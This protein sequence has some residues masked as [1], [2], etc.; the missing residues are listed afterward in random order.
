MN[1]RVTLLKDYIISFA[2]GAMFG[3]AISLVVLSFL[4]VK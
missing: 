4:P 2:M 1:V 3:A